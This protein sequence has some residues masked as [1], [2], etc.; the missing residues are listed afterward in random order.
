MATKHKRSGGKY[1]NASP[2]KS[3]G[4]ELRELRRTLRVSARVYVARLD[5][6]IARIAAWNAAMERI[7]APS[8]SDLRNIGDML[9]LV[10]R[11]DTKP[12]KGR[13]KDLRKIDSVV[14][15]L[16]FV[17]QRNGAD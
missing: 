4:R 13:R 1:V 9:S 12:E 15:D 2:S 10:R 11:L 14:S 8:R 6:E 16:A 5:A 17:C 7:E 3:L